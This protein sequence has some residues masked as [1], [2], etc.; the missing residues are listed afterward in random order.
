M[1]EYDSKVADMTN[2]SGKA[3]GNSH[4]AGLFVW[5]HLKHAGFTGDWAHF[6]IAYPSY[7]FAAERGTG[8]GVAVLSRYL[9]VTMP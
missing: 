3:N 6:D 5:K 2:L 9:G 1:Q 7:D 8:Y 4:L